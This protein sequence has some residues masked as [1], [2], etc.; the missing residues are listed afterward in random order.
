MADGGDKYG[1]TILR[2]QLHGAYPHPVDGCELSPRADAL[3]LNLMWRRPP[4][5]FD[6]MSQLARE[7]RRSARSRPL[8]EFC[9]IVASC[10]TACAVRP[11][12]PPTHGHW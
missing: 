2:K 9:L 4:G 3:F 8:C 1:A 7:R 11:P 12:A 6:S 5:A 10:V